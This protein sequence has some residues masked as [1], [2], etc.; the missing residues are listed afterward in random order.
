MIWW[1]LLLGRPSKELTYPIIDSKVRWDGDMLVPR[2]ISTCKLLKVCWTQ[3]FNPCQGQWS[4]LNAL[5]FCRTWAFLF[6][7]V[8]LDFNIQHMQQHHYIKRLP[9]VCCCGGMILCLCKKYVWVDVFFPNRHVKKLTS[10]SCQP[11][12][13]HRGK[14]QDGFERGEGS[15]CF[16]ARSEDA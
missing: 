8:N 9:S 14:T 13:V 4:R 12:G 16:L 6:Q 2:R 7:F 1:S 10:I 15:S 5:C 3:F 11:I